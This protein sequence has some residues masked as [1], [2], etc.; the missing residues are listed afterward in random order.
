MRRSR[1]RNR[2][3]LAATCAAAL[4]AAASGRA[5]AEEKS[6]AEVAAEAAA[7]RTEEIVFS[8]GKDLRAAP[9][10]ILDDLLGLAE[11]TNLG[12]L[13]VSGGLTAVST[14]EWDENVRDEVTDEP[15]R[16]GR[17]TNHFLDNSGQTY[18]HLAGAA[19]VYATSLFL[20][21][22]TLHELSLDA[23][24]AMTIQIPLTQGLKH[25]FSTRR[26]NG[27]R[28]GLPSGH[29]SSTFTLAA[30]A[31]ENLGLVPGLLG[32]AWGSLVALHRIDAG[33]HDLSDTILGAGLGVAIGFASAG[34]GAPRL[35]GREVKPW[36]DPRRGAKGVGLEYRF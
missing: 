2:L 28:N 11:P 29:V 13:A 22:P 4:L 23:L 30:V 20:Q 16:F 9:R 26:P 35:A 15:Q 33:H 21:S 5:L 36:V 17:R 12:I 34:N 3:G 18:N 7:A 1:L 19:A 32:Y 6:P 31:H 24:H 14:Q 27:G 25:A 10:R 8:F